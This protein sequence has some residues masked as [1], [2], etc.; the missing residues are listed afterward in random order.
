MGDHSTKAQLS[1]MTSDIDL[2]QLHISLIDCRYSDQCM[3]S[4]AWY[5]IATSD[6]MRSSASRYGQSWTFNSNISQIG[7]TLKD[8]S[9]FP[10]SIY[11]I[12][13]LTSLI[14]FYAIYKLKARDTFTA[15]HCSDPNLC[16]RNQFLGNRSPSQEILDWDHRPSAS[17]GE[18]H[19][20]GR[21]ESDNAGQCLTNDVMATAALRTGRN[22][23]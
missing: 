11:Y 4:R 2:I 3:P 8:S 5:A 18:D 19:L 9:D 1:D 10:L 12:T 14:L 22:P 7:T 23:M 17:L 20:S 6:A 21:V 15:P 13:T 16:F